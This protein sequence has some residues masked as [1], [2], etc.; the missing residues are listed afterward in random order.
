MAIVAT[1][2][3]LAAAAHR[4]GRSAAIRRAT[5]LGIELST[6]AERSRDEG[7]RPHPPWRP[8]AAGGAPAVGP[9][10]MAAESTLRMGAELRKAR[11]IAIAVWAATVASLS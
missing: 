10:P 8:A 11:P 5:S 3:F 7:K 1:L 4:C 9:L 6:H 2:P